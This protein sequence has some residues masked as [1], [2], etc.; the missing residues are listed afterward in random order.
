MASEPDSS[1]LGSFEG[2]ITSPSRLGK[3]KTSNISAQ[4]DFSI[5]GLGR[6]ILLAVNRSDYPVIQ[7]IAVYLAVLTMVINLIVD[8]MFKLV[9]PRVVLK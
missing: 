4:F 1:G 8:V 3:Q 7:A 9:D 2:K 6:E 5:P